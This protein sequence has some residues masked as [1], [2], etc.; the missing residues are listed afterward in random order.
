MALI[1]KRH[2]QNK[3]VLDKNI[4]EVT[5]LRYNLSVEVKQ[6]IKK[7]YQQLKS[8]IQFNYDESNILTGDQVRTLL[9]TKVE[10]GEL[11]EYLEKKSGIKE[12]QES[13]KAIDVLHKQI[14]HI[15]VIMIEFL[16]QE[17]SKYT[18]SNDSEHSKQKKAMTVLHQTLSIAKWINKFNPENEIDYKDLVLPKNLEDFQNLV[19]NA[20]DD[21]KT[22]ALT[23]DNHF[24]NK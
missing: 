11:L 6:A 22:L 15:C 19:S 4:E 18:M 20:M 7:S 21:M 2:L 9:G 13:M 12:T 16:R 1:D 14:K 10:R 17:V 23:R 3:A 8:E 5:M 24:E